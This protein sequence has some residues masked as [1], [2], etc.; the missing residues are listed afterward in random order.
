MAGDYLVDTNVLIALLRGEPGLAERV[1]G[2]DSL[3]IPFIALA[4]LCY[5]TRNSTRTQE[6]LARA[7]KLGQ[8]FD[9]LFPDIETVR[10][11]AHVRSTLKI[12]GRPIPEADLW[13]AS[14]ALQYRRVLVS[15][16]THFEHVP[17][18]QVESW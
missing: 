9:V 18:L 7:E 8:M 14:L 15:R 6:N 2:N 13:I 11:Y 3:A 17:G 12:L 1:S 10:T 5:G 16:D 4:E